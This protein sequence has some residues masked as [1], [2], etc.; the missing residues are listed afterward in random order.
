V[1]HFARYKLCKCTL[2]HLILTTNSFALRMVID[3]TMVMAYF[4]KSYHLTG[5][6]I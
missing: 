3:F 1:E 2:G 5:A 4:L 6:V